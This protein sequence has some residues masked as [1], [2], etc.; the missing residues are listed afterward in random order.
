MTPRKRR[1]SP[2]RPAPTIRQFAQE[3]GTTEAIM[4]SLV[5]SGQ[6]PTVDCNGVRLIPPAAQARYRALYGVP[7]S[8]S[9]TGDISA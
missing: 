4:R 9:D 3:V 8:A 5:R 6:I 7:T 1:S 2:R